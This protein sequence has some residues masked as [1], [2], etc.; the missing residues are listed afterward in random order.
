MT[1]KLWLSIKMNYQSLVLIVV[2]IFNGLFDDITNI[3][4]I[5]FGKLGS[6]SNSLFV[7]WNGI[8]VIK[9]NLISVTIIGVELTDN[10]NSL[11]V[12][13]YLRM[14]ACDKRK[15]LFFNF[16]FTI[17]NVV[18]SPLI[19]FYPFGFRNI[20]IYDHRIIIPF[21]YL[22]LICSPLQSRGGR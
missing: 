2:A 3:R 1:M 12:N 21:Y 19:I 20:V 4:P 8:A 10:F 15:P 14:I 6:D 7:N 16:Y 18:F 11:K 22:F 9:R 17:C 13:Y 5:V